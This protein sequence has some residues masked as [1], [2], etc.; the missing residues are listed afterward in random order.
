MPGRI[1]RQRQTF[2]I[3]PGFVDALSAL[4]IVIIFL[5]MVFT[6]SQFFLGDI[7]SGRNQALERVNQKLTE[8]SKV[9]SLEQETNLSL[10]KKITQLTTDLE[11]STAS[12]EKMSVQLAELITQRDAL[13]KKLTDARQIIG[14][15]KKKIETQLAE[16]IQI[17]RDITALKDVRAALE[18]KVSK[19]AQTLAERDRSLGSLRDRSKELETRMADAKNRT[20]LAQK[21]IEKKELTIRELS[22]QAQRIGDDLTKEQ[23]ASKDFRRKIAVL[24]N[25]LVALRLQLT[26]LNAALEASETRVAAQ[27][28]QIVSLGKRL[29][30]ALASK[31][32]ELARYRSEFFGRL[33]E[34]LG[35]RS[36]V[37]I[38]G[39]RFVLQ[40]EVLFSTGSADLNPIGQEQIDKLAATLQEISDRIPD[41]LN[42]VLRVDGHTDSRPISTPKFPSNWEL[43]AARAISV[44]KALINRGLQADRLVAAGFGEFQ[45]LDARNDEVAYLRNRRIEFKLTQR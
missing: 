30:E 35:K 37:R 7:L 33:R 13:Q 4:L 11:A 8:L 20:A 25:Q 18:K 41:D 19:L 15:D 2:D 43:S 31:V 16:I 5:L 21:E 3:W 45:P 32:Q 22:A 26:R 1:R 6:L 28:V 38:V 42:W 14:N 17:N 9:L 12:R 24:N 36:G 44:V 29:N 10:S 34:A 40:S 39:D 27:D 23:R